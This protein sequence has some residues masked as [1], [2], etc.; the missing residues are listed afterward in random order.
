MQVIIKFKGEVRVLIL[1]PI[2]SRL[3]VPFLPVD[4]DSVIV[5]WHKSVIKLQIEARGEH[6]AFGYALS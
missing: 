4:G 5:P 6:T 3:G 2:Q 1:D